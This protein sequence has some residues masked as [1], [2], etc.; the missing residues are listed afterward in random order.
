[1]PAFPIRLVATAGLLFVGSQLSAQ[2]SRPSDDPSLDRPCSFV[3]AAEM[4]GLLG[5]PVVT[6]TDE[7]F[8]CKYVVGK[9]W[10]ETKLMNL[11]LKVTRDIYDYNRAHGRP[12]PGVGDQAYQ[13]GAT[14]AAKVGDVLVVVDGSNVPRPPDDA[15][16]KAIALKI[17]KGI[18]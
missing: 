18:P 8:R 9:G 16:L 3:T 10:L 4:A 15:R 5:T 1:M 11:E 17:I 2:P 12:M 13:L 7:H 6:A 14:L